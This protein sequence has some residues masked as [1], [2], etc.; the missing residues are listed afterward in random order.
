VNI[1]ANVKKNTNK[2]GLEGVGGFR[3]AKWVVINNRLSLLGCKV[4]ASKN[5]QT[6]QLSMDR[7]RRND[8]QNAWRL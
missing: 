6:S 7:V 2:K 5:M 1:T 4:W 8:L 3:G